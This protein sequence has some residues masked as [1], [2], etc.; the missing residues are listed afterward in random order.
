VLLNLGFPAATPVGFAGR[1]DVV[2][3]TLA[4][5]HPDWSHVRAMLIRPDGYLAWATTAAA[6][7]VVGPG[8]F[9]RG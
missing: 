5:S 1:L 8:V 4:G 3:A 9:R 6:G 7:R 2:T